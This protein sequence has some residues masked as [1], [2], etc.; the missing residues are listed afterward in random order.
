[1]TEWRVIVDEEETEPNLVDVFVADT[2]NPFGNHAVAFIADQDGERFDAYPRGTRVDFEVSD[3]LLGETPDWETRFTGFVVERDEY[4]DGGR[5]M[6]EVECYSF[7]QF[8]RYGKVTEET[9]GMTIFGALE[10]I[11]ERDTP[12]NWN[13]DK[14]T[15]GNNQVL[16]REFRGVPV[17][18]TLLEIAHKSENEEFGVDDEL[19]FFFRPRETTHSPRDIDNTQWLHEDIPEEGKE[20]VNEVTVYFDDGDERVTVDAGDAKLDVQESLDLPKPP[21]QRLEKKY[22]EITDIEDARDKGEQILQERAAKMT[23]E[24]TTYGLYDTYPGDLINIEI[25][26]RGL[27]DEFVIAGIEYEWQSDETTVTIINKTGYQDEVL[28]R[29]ADAVDK[30]E[31]EDVDRDA[32]ENRVT[33]TTVGVLIEVGGLVEESDPPESFTVEGTHTI[34]ENETETYGTVYN[35]GTIENEG[36]LQSITSIEDRPFDRVRFTNV[37]RNLARDAWRDQAEIDIS[38]IAIGTDGSGLSRSNT[39]LANETDREP[40]DE[41]LDGDT[42]VEYT[43]TIG[44]FIEEVG[45]VTS[46]DELIARCT[47]DEAV[48]VAGDI[49]VSLAVHNDDSVTRGVVTDAGQEAVRDTL[50]DNDPLL[51]AHY[52]YGSDGSDVSESDTELGN[53]IFSLNIKEL[54]VVSMD[55]TEEWEDAIL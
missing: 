43:A 51:P 9:E 13:P 47:F 52:A 7:D 45:L 28:V 14:I 1:M 4:E 18:E 44:G 8:L 11:I 54:P 50:A 12:V 46:D 37:G 5:D 49:T 34:G 33:E 15:I 19:D 21:E 38:Y 31:L 32:V 22:P 55:T 41:T 26:K 30:I 6:L 25:A 39:E 16:T 24:V 23:G 36:E 27:D 35:D 20:E 53:E 3:S 17:E 2:A 40:A 42:A 10:D 48:N 29:I